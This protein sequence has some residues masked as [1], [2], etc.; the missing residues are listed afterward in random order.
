MHMKYMLS[1]LFFCIGS[2]LLAQD[3][4]MVKY[5]E[6]ISFE[7]PPEMK[8][9]M[10]DIPS[11]VQA[12]KILVFEG[13]KMSYV[14]GEEEVDDAFSRGRKNRWVRYM[15]GSRASTKFFDMEA[16]L[17]MEKTNRYRKEFLI[18][19]TVEAI[20]WKI[21][22]G[23]QRDILGYTCMKG[24]Y[25]RDSTTIEAWFTP[26]IPVSMGPDGLHGLPGL[27]LAVGYGEN[28]AILAKE[29]L[30]DPEEGVT[31]TTLSPSKKALS[32]QEFDTLME[33]R[34]EEMKK[35]WGGNA[36]RRKMRGNY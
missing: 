23:E 36:K 21:S 2:L 35:M 22:A 19:D 14:E 26:Q 30:L 1:L 27:I 5:E 15:A 8:A 16:G 28:K 12:S 4:G 32:R 13:Q 20:Q 18:Q 3:S 9:R 34:R 31:L 33:E 6:D 25:Q 29:I 11:N 10:K 17:F 7:I 24:I